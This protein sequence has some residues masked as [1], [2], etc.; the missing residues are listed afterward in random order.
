MRGKVTAAPKNK[1]THTVTT[2]RR[3]VFHMDFGFV[4]G[5]DYK[6]KNEKGKLITSRDGYNSY[7]IVVDSFTRY[8]WV[9]LS[10]KKDPPMQ[11]VKMF[12]Y[13]YG[14]KHGINRQIRC[15]QGGELARSAKFRETV[16]LCGYSIELTGADNSSQNGVAER[17]NRTFGNMMRTM[18]L[19]AGLSSKFWSYA[20]VQA[21]FIKNR[22]PH[23]HHSFIKTPF[24]MLTGRKPN[25]KSLKIFGSRV[26]AK[27]PGTKSAKLDDNTSQG[28]FLHHTSTTSISKFLDD[29]T[30]R[31]KT[32]S[33]LTYD[34]IL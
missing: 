8:T 22:V 19:N 34:E 32:A 15:D 27:N 24:E 31:E 14:L 5:S 12:L 3:Q 7:L 33:H 11:T 10:S 28:I 17:P 21:V 20:L 13:R 1:Q 18:L 30:G 4:R 6:S 29:S 9:F 23:S 16:S 2:G 26:V 25:L